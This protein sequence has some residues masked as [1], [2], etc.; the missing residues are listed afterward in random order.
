MIDSLRDMP[1][2]ALGHSLLTSPLTLQEFAKLRKR[3]RNA[4]STMSEAIDE[5]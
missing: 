4:V 5:V 1:M 2:S 3:K